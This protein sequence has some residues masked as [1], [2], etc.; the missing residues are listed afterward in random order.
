MIN[1]KK[2]DS[3]TL[4]LVFLVFFILTLFTYLLKTSANI[5]EQITYHDHLVDMQLINKSFDN[6]LLKKST[7]INYDDINLKITNFDKKIDFIDAPDAHG[8][9]KKNY[10]N[11]VSDI[12]NS[13]EEKQIFI[14]KFKSNSASLLNS[15]HYVFELNK[16]IQEDTSQ[17]YE[18]RDVVTKQTL[19]LMKYY[20]NS[21]TN[22]KQIKDNL[23]FLKQRL[24]S[25]KNNLE[26]ELFISHTSRNVKRIENSHTIQN[27]L[28]TQ[29][30]LEDNLN[31]LHMFFE[32]NYN[33][34]MFVE[35]V[36]TTIF[37]I[38]ALIILFILLIMYKR[39]LVIKNELYGFK[40]AVQNSDNSIVM[41][42]A[43]KNI[44][45]VNDAFLEHTGYTREE[46]IG[47]NPRILKSGEIPQSVYNDLNK[48]LKNG[49]KWDGEFIN[50]RKDK[51]LYYEKASIMP[52]YVDNKVKNYLAIKL[53]ITDYIKQKDELQFLALHDS[54]TKLPNRVSIES[55]IDK[56][57]KIAQRNK[58]KITILFIDLDRFK[59]I[60][61]TLGHDVGDELLIQTAKRI[62]K[63]IKRV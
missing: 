51:S 6:F 18:T 11:I 3:I 13:F 9:F 20:I 5:D 44:T 49:K 59:T 27:I 2:I 37:F 42:D 22:K 30:S 43:D 33:E 62:T 48:K 53:N 26:L 57:I 36:I 41:T 10:S 47:E 60:N 32:E 63:V 1:M 25:D 35:K 23:K 58:S 31:Q 8:L 50:V 38:T 15:I 61:D 34:N 14:E 16:L 55:S 56:K 45:Y 7:F 17:T 12:K 19:L 39:S 29:G 21:Y 40:Y 24:K 28:Y 52:I 46:V 54:L 4:V